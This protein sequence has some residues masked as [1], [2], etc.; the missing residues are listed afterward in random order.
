MVVDASGFLGSGYDSNSTP[1]AMVMP[2]FIGSNKKGK[3]DTSF[4]LLILIKK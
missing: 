4:N 3:G 1:C 2:E